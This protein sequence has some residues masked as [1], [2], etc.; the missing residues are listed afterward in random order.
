MFA[1]P[2]TGHTRGHAPWQVQLQQIV[3]KTI[4]EAD[5]D[6]DGKISYDEFRQMISNTDELDD[7]MTVNLGSQ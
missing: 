1:G 7:R 2:L 3:D 6:R 5:I 4:L